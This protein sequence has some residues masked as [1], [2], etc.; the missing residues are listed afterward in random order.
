MSQA[1]FHLVVT[2]QQRTEQGL[3]KEALLLDSNKVQNVSAYVTVILKSS[4]FRIF[5]VAHVTDGIQFHY[6]SDCT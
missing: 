4:V 6:V 2:L 1:H 5:A 3:M